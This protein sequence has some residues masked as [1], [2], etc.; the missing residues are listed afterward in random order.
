MLIQQSPDFT[1]QLDELRQSLDHWRREGRTPRRIPD[2]IWDQAVAAA[3]VHGVGP[4]AKDLHLDHAKLKS[5]LASKSPQG[6]VAAR[7]QEPPI[8]ATFF[9]LVAPPQLSS[10]L[11][12]CVLSVESGRGGRMRVEVSG[13]DVPGLA[14]LVR[15][16]VV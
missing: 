8:P 14:L 10:S 6:L 4:V 9:E 5:L 3:A 15:E 11:G 2:E 12:Q 7:T 1:Q 13:L 16:F